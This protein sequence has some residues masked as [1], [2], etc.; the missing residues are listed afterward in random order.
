MFIILQK[1][2]NSVYAH[3]WYLVKIVLILFLMI[4]SAYIFAHAKTA[5]LWSR[6]QNC[7]PI[8]SLFCK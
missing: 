4:K 3:N 1:G 2:T 7:D 5:E 8:L 6:V